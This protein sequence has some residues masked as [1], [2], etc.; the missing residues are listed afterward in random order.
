MSEVLKKILI[1]DDEPSILKLLK[2]GL[3]TV[4]YAVY[5]AENGDRCFQEVLSVHPDAI[6]L[7]L[8]LPD[9]KGVEVIRKLREWSRIPII[10]LTVQDS[11]EEKVKALDHGADD[12]ITKPFSMPELLARLRVALRHAQAAEE[13]PI[14]KTGPLEID[15]NAHLVKVDGEVI[16]LTAT[17]YSILSMLAKSAGKVVTHRMLL[18]EIW[19]PNSVE[20]TQYLRVY[21]GQIRRKL[22]T[23]EGL[24]EF[25]MTEAGVGYRLLAD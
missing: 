14:F 3:E 22:Q 17:E 24:P 16:K 9:I 5:Q 11:D 7:D 21:L 6:V 8:G 18:K 19:G 15:R 2:L 20:H 13:T 10:V 25:I 1:V 12:Y 23:K 4:G